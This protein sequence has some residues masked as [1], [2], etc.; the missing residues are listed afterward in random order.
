MSNQHRDYR[1]GEEEQKTEKRKCKADSTGKKQDHLQQKGLL[2]GINTLLPTNVGS[3]TDPPLPVRSF[4]TC[5]GL[6]QVQG[7]CKP[8]RRAKTLDLL[9]FGVTLYAW[10]HR[11]PWYLST[12]FHNQRDLTPACFLVIHLRISLLLFMWYCFII[13][14]LLFIEF[15]YFQAAVIPTTTF[16]Q[17]FQSTVYFGWFIPKASFCVSFWERRNCTQSLSKY[18]THLKS[19]ENIHKSTLYKASCSHRCSLFL[20]QATVCDGWV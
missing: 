16:A 15:I 6:T 13:L 14:F 9:Q 8:L 11:E 2:A 7:G 1:R 18:W 19:H 10:R 3:A 4:S 12:R 17:Q 5:H 20:L